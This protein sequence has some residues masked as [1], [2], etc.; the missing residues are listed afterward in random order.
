MHL[1][2]SV[3]QKVRSRVRYQEKEPTRTF[4]MAKLPSRREH[5]ADVICC[6]IGAC[7]V[8]FINCLVNALECIGVS[9][10]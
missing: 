4:C 3:S 7:L 2:V 6:L 9:E 10:S 5:R 1:S 8:T